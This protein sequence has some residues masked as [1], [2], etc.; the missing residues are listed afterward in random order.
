MSLTEE[1]LQLTVGV[2]GQEKLSD[3]TKSLKAVSE[4]EYE[5]AGAA[6]KAGGYELVPSALDK[7]AK[8]APQAESGLK[9][10]TAATKE[11]TAAKE[12]LAVA[13][14]RATSKLQGLGQ[15]G[16]QTGRIVQD[17]AQGGVG[18]VLNNIEGF[19]MAVGGGPGMAGA[20]TTLG[21]AAF[22]AKPLIVSAAE[23]IGMFRKEVDHT[24]P[25]VELLT[26]RI[27][28]LSKKEIKLAIDRHELDVA[29]A[30]LKRLT[31]AQIAFDA[32]KEGRNSDQKEA[33]AGIEKAMEDTGEGADIAATLKAKMIEEIEG[34]N[35]IIQGAPGRM[36]EFESKHDPNDIS[37][38]VKE[39]R[40]ALQKKIA[41]EVATQ[42]ELIKKHAE[43]EVGGIIDAAKSGKDPEA[44]GNLAARLDNAG[45]EDVA[46]KVRASTPEAARKRR[47]QKADRE[48]FW[49]EQ[50]AD[51][52]AMK[53]PLKERSEQQALH[54]RLTDTATDVAGEAAVA[55]AKAQA[56]HVK[57]V[58]RLGDDRAK[59]TAKAVGQFNETDLDEQAAAFAGKMRSGE[60]GGKLNSRGQMVP[61]D[62]A[63]QEKLMARELRKQMGFVPNKASKADV[64][65]AMSKK[66]FGE[67]DDTKAQAALA[68][69]G[70]ATNAT[71]RAAQ[72]NE[73]ALQTSRVL[74]AR[75]KAAE[76]QIARQRDDWL[77]LQDNARTS[78][79]SR[80]PR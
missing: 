37:A 38:G 76:S 68:V 80:V 69:G 3:L 8:V 45:R 27:E 46:A 35:A 15:T 11:A 29:E 78:A 7:V 21:V 40:E 34:S 24:K 4:A 54:R 62:Q 17:F 64:V 63:R 60:I 44:A 26:A 39:D 1:F 23:S 14:E 53:L 9:K 79:G 2:K 43:L 12:K 52:G 47:N 59:R 22:V 56:E 72:T 71:E 51:L 25:T 73:I 77:E 30:Q 13:T 36:A 57:E 65:E 74:L 70:K 6:E 10:V 32:L 16:L 66:A 19:A 28:E 49:D 75:L 18:G 48:M 41:E 58:G 42:R 67:A 50:D 20:L 55:G 5:L 61:L 33:G 31:K